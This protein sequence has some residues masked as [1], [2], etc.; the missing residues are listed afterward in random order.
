MAGLDAVTGW[1]VHR[2]VLITNPF[3]TST[4][5]PRAESSVLDVCAWAVRLS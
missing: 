4:R 2:T 1:A 5:V 3:R